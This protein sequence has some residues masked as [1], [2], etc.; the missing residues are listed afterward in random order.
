MEEIMKN[1][2]FSL[3]RWV[4]VISA[5]TQLI[6]GLEGLFAPQLVHTVTWPLPFEPIPDLWLRYDGITFLAMSLGAIF[7]LSQDNW[8]AARTFL[9][10]AAPMVAAE[11]IVT[12]LAALSPAGAPPVVWI[13]IVLALIYVPLVVMAWAQQSAAQAHVAV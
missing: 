4:L 10:I 2:L 13:Y 7:A 9:A 11:V 8:I 12:V 1:R 3:T 6:F 5:V